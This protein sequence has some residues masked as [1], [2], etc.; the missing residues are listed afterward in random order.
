GGSE[1][2]CG[3]GGE[4]ARAVRGAPGAGRSSKGGTKRRGRGG[5]RRS[6]SRAS[7]RRSRAATDLR[8]R[9]RPEVLMISVLPTTTCSMKSNMP[10]RAYHH[11]CGRRDRL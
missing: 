2:C 6:C 9:L 7:A 10:G 1:R 3:G 4:G 11:P 5:P 8:S